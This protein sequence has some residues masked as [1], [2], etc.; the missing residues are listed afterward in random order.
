MVH[1]FQRRNKTLLKLWSLKLQDIRRATIRD[2]TQ[3]KRRRVN[4][5]YVD[6]DIPCS[7]EFEADIHVGPVDV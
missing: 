3:T 1:P 2:S 7:P 4:A 6:G 5:A